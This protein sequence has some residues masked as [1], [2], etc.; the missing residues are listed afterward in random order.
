M[1]DSPIGRRK[2]LKRGVAGGV[3]AL[4][5]TA[6][7]LHFLRLPSDRTSL[8][9]STAFA[10]NLTVKPEPDISS[11][12]IV[13][14]GS[15]GEMVRAA[16]DAVGGMGR[17][18]KSGETVAIKP[19]AGWEREPKYASNTN[20]DVIHEVV[21][22]CFEA[23]AGKV[24][25]SGV[26]CNDPQRSFLRS[27]IGKAAEDAGAKVVMPARRNFRTVDL[28]GRILGKWPVIY[29]FLDA[30]KV[31]NIPVAKQHGLSEITAAMKNWFGLI[32]GKRNRLHQNIH[33][34]IV[35]LSA[36]MQ[37]TL[38]I[39]DAYRILVRNG[40]QGGN[41]NDVENPKIIAA[42][43][44]QVAADAYAATLFGKHALDI[45]YIKLASKQGLGTHDY[46][47]LK[48]KIISL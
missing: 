18:I 41:L 8:L 36:F 31:I 4:G 16:L 39:I 7:A 12:S 6:T 32:S 48:P 30:D 24:I 44:D 47:S 46:E 35:D 37:P 33:Q 13:K 40:P 10:R 19:N 22:M 15:P 26:S 9:A 27:G 17:F 29:P 45:D 21:K 14:G 1:S 43:T 2:F 5:S 20:P 42:S 11:M 34:S 38:T 23:G 28:G 25:V 3:L